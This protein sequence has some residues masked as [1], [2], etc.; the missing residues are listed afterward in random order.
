MEHFAPTVESGHALKRAHSKG[1]MN[2]LGPELQ[3]K[4]RREISSDRTVGAVRR[5]S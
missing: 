2:I 3:G 1:N 4:P 5:A